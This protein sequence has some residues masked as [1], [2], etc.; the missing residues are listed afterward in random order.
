MAF[1]TDD[2]PIVKPIQDER[3]SSKVGRE[4]VRLVGEHA[5]AFA[6]LLGSH[7]CHNADIRADVDHPIS[8]LDKP[9]NKSLLAEFVGAV[10]SDVRRDRDVFANE[11]N[12]RAV[13]RLAQIT[14]LA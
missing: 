1:L 9:L 11:V 3:L 10:Q 8:P 12:L 6:D 14:P 5:P 2:C 4:R 7:Q 13:H